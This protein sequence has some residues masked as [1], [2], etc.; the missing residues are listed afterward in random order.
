[1]MYASAQIP[2]L[3][4]C[5]GCPSLLSG[6]CAAVAQPT[7]ERLSRATRQ[8]TFEA[9]RQIVADDQASPY[10]AILRWGFV[11][12]QHNGEDGRRRI[13]GLTLPGEIIGLRPQL[14]PSHSYEAATE[15]GL[16]LIDRRAFDRTLAASPDLQ[17]AILA[18]RTAE[19]DRLHWLTWV[20]ATLRP[21]ERIAAFL[22][23]ALTMM[24][25]EPKPD[26]SVI[27]TVVLSRSDI[28]DLLGTTPETFCRVIQKLAAQRTIDIVDPR[29]FRIR[30]PYA[31]AAM[32]C[33]IGA[34][35]LFAGA[36]NASSASGA[37]PQKRRRECPVPQPLTVVNALLEAVS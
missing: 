1:M 18:Q 30:D 9:G 15:A 12:L 22:S 35:N 23:M 25:T 31:L 2:S 6:L 19:L 27:L 28:A 29:H 24:P 36:W 26:G 3:S 5:L 34:F 21:E 7:F 32:G 33:Q 11:R 17:S 14:R 37:A 20:L 16:C 10:L 13:V 8:L 4:H